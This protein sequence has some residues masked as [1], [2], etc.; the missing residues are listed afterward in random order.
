MCMIWCGKENTYIRANKRIIKN[1]NQH[2]TEEKPNDIHTK[3]SSQLHKSAPGTKCQ[4]H[5]KI[6][7]EKALNHEVD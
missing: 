1:L 6:N 7:Q 3:E 4:I 5:W 2:E